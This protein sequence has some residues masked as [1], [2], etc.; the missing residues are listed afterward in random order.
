MSS[1]LIAYQLQTR[2]KPEPKRAQPFYMTPA[3]SFFLSFSI[4]FFF[5]IINFQMHAF[6]IVSLE[7]TDKAHR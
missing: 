4:F 3:L 5:I 1:N 2:A 7:E 6:V